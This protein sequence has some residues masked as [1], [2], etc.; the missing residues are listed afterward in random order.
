[1]DEMYS[2]YIVSIHIFGYKDPKYRT[3]I[4]SQSNFDCLPAALRYAKKHI[5]DGADEITIVVQKWKG[6]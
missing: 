1:M 4:K 6:Q 5:K 2:T 3:N